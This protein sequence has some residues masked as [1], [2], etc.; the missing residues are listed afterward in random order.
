MYL[1]PEHEQEISF[2]E[3][4]QITRLKEAQ[5]KELYQRLSKETCQTPEAFN[6]GDF[7]LRDEK[8][9]DQ[10]RKAKVSW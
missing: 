8:I 4:T 5:V 3:K 9:D 10:R 6:F 2:R 7:K 1:G